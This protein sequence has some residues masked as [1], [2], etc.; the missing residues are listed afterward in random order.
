MSN[1]IDNEGSTGGLVVHRQRVTAE[2]DY[3]SRA[4]YFDIDSIANQQGNKVD[5]QGNKVALHGENKV[6]ILAAREL[7]ALNEEVTRARKQHKKIRPEALIRIAEIEEETRKLV[8]LLAE[9]EGAKSR[10]RASNQYIQPTPD[11]VDEVIL[12]TEENPDDILISTPADTRNKIRSNSTI[13]FVIAGTTA[14]LA[15][16]ALC[17]GIISEIRELIKENDTPV[18]EPIA[19][20]ISVES[21]ADIKRPETAVQTPPSTRDTLVSPTTLYGRVI[22]EIE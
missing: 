12:D 6:N 22:A 8:I 9:K 13:R 1:E 16:S 5:L 17:A 18:K 7:K 4:D 3:G 2:I 19:D 20:V 15:S 11:L 21:L 10:A 14:V